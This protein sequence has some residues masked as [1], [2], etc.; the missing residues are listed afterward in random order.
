MFFFPDVC[1]MPVDHGRCSDSLRKWFYDPYQRRCQTFAY[2]GCEGNG[3]R[4][5]T[6]QECEAECIYHDTIHP[7]GNSSQEAHISKA[8]AAAF[9]AFK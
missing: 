4:F 6:E 8:A 5:S 9:V 2:S 1:N 3:N 7:S